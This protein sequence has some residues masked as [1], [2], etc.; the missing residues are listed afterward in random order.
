MKT[1]NQALQPHCVMFS[2]VDLSQCDSTRCRLRLP[3]PWLSFVSLDVA[4]SF[5]KQQ[6][7]LDD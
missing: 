5:A 6:Q 1:P 4:A 2:Y 7:P 3:E